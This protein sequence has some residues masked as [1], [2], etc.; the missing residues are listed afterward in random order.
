MKAEV[1]QRLWTP[2]SGGPSNHFPDK[3]TLAATVS[4]AILVEVEEKLRKNNE[5]VTDPAY[6]IVRGMCTHTQLAV[7]DPRQTTIMLR[8][9]DWVSAGNHQL[10]KSVQDDVAKGITT[11]RCARRCEDVGFLQ[12]IGTGYFSSL[13]ILDQK[14]TADQAIDLATRAF[15]LIL[16][17]FGLE[18][19]EAVR[20]VSDSARDI[21]KD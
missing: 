11:G 6:R 17:G 3:E 14:L 15:S 9:A 2:N 16:C 20:I 19:D 13:R 1:S 12:I 10:H 18:E 7:S 5:N 4:D 21:I 8:G